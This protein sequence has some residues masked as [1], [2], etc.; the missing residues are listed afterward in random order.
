[1]KVSPPDREGADGAP[2][3]GG[4]EDY[5][6]SSP[7]CKSWRCPFEAGKGNSCCGHRPSPTVVLRASKEQKLN[8]VGEGYS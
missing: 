8:P 3:G 5:G 2:L 6:R 7:A 1:M 4:K